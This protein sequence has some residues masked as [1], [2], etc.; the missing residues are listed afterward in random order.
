MLGSLTAIGCWEMCEKHKFWAGK[1]IVIVT[2]WVGRGSEAKISIPIDAPR[3][4]DLEIRGF[5]KSFLIYSRK[6]WIFLFVGFSGL[7]VSSKPPV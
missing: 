1:D 5:G 2:E 7:S 3:S 6:I 4:A